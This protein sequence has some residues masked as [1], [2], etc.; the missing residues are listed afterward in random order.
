MGATAH[1]LTVP[2]ICPAR[3]T[4]LELVTALSEV[5]NDENEVVATALYMLRTGRVVLRGNFRNLPA[6]EF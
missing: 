1:I 4:L 5:T 2:V 3:L 6:S